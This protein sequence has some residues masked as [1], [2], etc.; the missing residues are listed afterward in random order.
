MRS[1]RPATQ[2]RL[3]SE[4]SHFF[5]R[6]GLVGFKLLG[7]VGALGCDRPV[8]NNQGVSKRANP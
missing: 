1:N 3:G 4:P 8:K 5:P 7:C 6:R 2:V